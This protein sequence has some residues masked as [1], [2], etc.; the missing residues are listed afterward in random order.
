MVP[1]SDLVLV[2]DHVS[3][4][5]LKLSADATKHILHLSRLGLDLLARGNLF[6]LILALGLSGGLPTTLARHT[7]GND[8]LL[9]AI[10]A[11]ILNGG[12]ALWGAT[13]ATCAGAGSLVDRG[14]LR[15]SLGG[16]GSSAAATGSVGCLARLLDVVQAM[17]Y[18][19]GRAIWSIS[20]ARWKR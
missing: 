6:I 9:R 2:G 14:L 3:I 20:S 12:L 4:V 19:L 18:G 5:I 1:H 8:L 17:R 15:R 13:T 7:R 11:V 10:M 16:R